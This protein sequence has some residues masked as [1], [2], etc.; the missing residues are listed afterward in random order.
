MELVLR[1]VAVY[2]FLILVFRIAGKRSLADTTTFDLI[3]LLI[4]SEATQQ[5]L[6]G[7]DF[8]LTGAAIVISTL[9][10][11]EI[12]IGFIQ[13]RVKWFSKLIDSVPLVIAE[14]GKPI[15]RR[16]KKCRITEE[17]LLATARQLHGLERVDQI[18]YAVL[19]RGGKIS[20][21]PS[22]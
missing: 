1:A 14:N 22:G 20:I 18:K 17:D 11:L 10:G 4:I 9:V 3:L 5:A 19:E 2:A 15:A 6:M 8:S 13:H 21:I 12:L 7:Q 16:M